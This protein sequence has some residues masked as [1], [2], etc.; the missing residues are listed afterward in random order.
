MLPTNAVA[1][2]CGTA[3]IN[4]SFST[5]GGA[6][7][8]GS[9]RVPIDDATQTPEMKATF[10][11]VSAG[12]VIQTFLK[13][14]EAGSQSPSYSP[15]AGVASN[16]GVPSL[17]GVEL[18]APP[19]AAQSNVAQ[20]TRGKRF[21]DALRAYA[22]KFKAQTRGLTGLAQPLP[23]QLYALDTDLELLA[24]TWEKQ[25]EFTGYRGRGVLESL[26]FGGALESAGG[27]L[28]MASSM[29]LASGGTMSDSAFWDKVRASQIP[30]VDDFPMEGFLKRFRLG[31]RAPALPANWSDELAY[32]MGDSLYLPASGRLLIQVGMGTN[33]DESTYARPPLNLVVALDISGSM[34]SSDATGTNSTRLDG[35]KRALE[36]LLSQLKSG[37]RLSLVAF[38]DQ[39]E[40]LEQ[41]LAIQPGASL[42]PL[43]KKVRELK[44]RGGT[45]I[46]VVQRAGYSMLNTL[47]AGGNPN[48]QSRLVVIT[49]A[50]ATSGEL[51][52]AEMELAATRAAQKNQFTTVIGV[53]RDFSRD[54]ASRLANAAGGMFFYAAN[55]DELYKLFAQFDTRMVSFG[56]GFDAQLVFEGLSGT[57]RVVAVYGSGVS[58]P[59]KETLPAGTVVNGQTVLNVPTLAFADRRSVD[60]NAG[61][62]AFIIEVQLT[63]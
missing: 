41:G 21:A 5:V 17:G 9:V 53:G 37:D 60:E 23:R 42:E 50:L 7:H 47:S 54:L 11:V 63:P 28:E 55:G 57:A 16:S 51:N 10:F 48:S 6:R 26:S 44:P 39:M 20:G 45:N 31:T 27:G 8:A 1:T 18:L 46:G 58:D 33:V 34:S 30:S 19:E 25:Q 59:E 38:D 40:V 15:V 29:R 13:D 24:S 43:L 14:W 32:A 12:R 4:Y 62:G 22:Q 35:A 49:D 36:D 56:T 3:I 52:A 61:G 2:V